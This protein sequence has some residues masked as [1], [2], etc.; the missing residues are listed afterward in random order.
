[1]IL[2]VPARPPYFSG[3]PCDR[4]FSLLAFTILVWQLFSRYFNL[5]MRLATL[6]YNAL[7]YQF[8]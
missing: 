7:F 2:R 3:I 8:F 5:A 1:M 4:T 6:L